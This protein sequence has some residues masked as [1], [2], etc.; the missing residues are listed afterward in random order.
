[1]SS[2]IYYFSATGNSLTVARRIA[3]GMEDCAVRS[4]AAEPPQGPVGGPG[5]SVGLVFPVF[6]VGMPRL[7]RHFVERLNLLGGTYCFAFIT[8]GGNAADT[9][10]MLEDLLGKK[11]VPL[12]YAAGATMPG[13]Y[14]VKYPA[15][16]PDVIQKLIGDAMHKADA[17]AAAAARG[18]LR[19]TERKARLFSKAA[20][21]CYLYRGIAEWDEKFSAAD[22]CT[23]CGLCAGV[24]PVRNIRMEDRRPVWQHRCEHCLACLQWCPCGAIEYGGKTVGRQ[25]YHNPNVQAEDIVRQ[26]G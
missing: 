2:T 6:Y 22:R 23:G 25:R 15:F 4:M 18:E 3:E 21:R 26:K 24:C 16:A 20:N 17:A 13:N 19:P 10:G 1:M 5:H 12:S 7:V 9:L 11:G 8:F 14:I